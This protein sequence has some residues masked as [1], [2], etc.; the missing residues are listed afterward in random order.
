MRWWVQTLT[1]FN[2]LTRHLVAYQPRQAVRHGQQSLQVHAA[3]IAHDSTAHAFD[4]AANTCL[5][6]AGVD[7]RGDQID[8]I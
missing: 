3:V 5:H 7:L 4:T 2:E 6:D 1:G 8:R